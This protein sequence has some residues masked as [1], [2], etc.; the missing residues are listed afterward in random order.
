MNH[1]KQ[2]DFILFP[3]PLLKLWKEHTAKCQGRAY[4]HYYVY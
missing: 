2:M 4:L 1:L 3:S